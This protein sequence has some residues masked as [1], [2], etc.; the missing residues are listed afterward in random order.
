MNQNDLLSRCKWN[1]LSAIA[2]TPGLLLT[3]QKEA[4]SAKSIPDKLLEQES[5]AVTIPRQKLPSKLLNKPTLTQLPNPIPPRNIEPLEIPK[6]E[7]PPKPQLPI[8]QNPPETPSPPDTL[9]IPQTITVKKFEFAGNTAFSDQELA[10]IVAEITNRP[11]SFAEL[12]QVEEKIRNK[13]TAGC[14]ENGEQPCY[15]NSG[16]FIPANQTFAKDGAIVR[17]QI[18]EGSIEQINITGLKKLNQ[19]YVRSRLQ[20]GISQPLEREQL[21]ETLQILQLDPLIQNFSANLTAGTR[22]EKSILE[23]KLIEADSF[24]VELFTNNGRSPS[25]G[26]WRRGFRVSEDN[27]LGIGDS[28]F[29]EYTNTD[30]S[31]RIDLGYTAPLNASNTTINIIGQIND[32]EVIEEPFDRLDIEGNSFR[33]EL[34]LR[35]PILRTPEQELAVGL[36][37]SRQESITKLL[38]RNFAISSGADDNGS[39]RISALRFYQEYTKRT[40]EDVFAVRSQFSVGLDVFD[41]TVNEDPLPDSL[42]FAWRGQ[43]QYVRRL[44][45]DTLIVLRSDFQLAATNLVPLEQISIGGPE[46]VRGYRQDAILTDNGFFASAE[47]RLPILRA[48]GVQGILQ[49]APFLDFGVGWNAA[50]VEDPEE[51]TFVSLGLG[52]RWQ[53]GDDFSARLEY[54]IPLIDVEDTNETLQENGLYFSINYS[55]F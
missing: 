31:N 25:V 33:I 15:I 46:S 20:R 24:A 9:P 54:G 4:V 6:E 53:M 2:L 42:F 14:N 43:G 19:N 3:S 26:T 5:D 37:G 11:I 21:L 44:A 48:E 27:L 17:V 36:S 7:P 47:V 34:G 49:I 55:P 45:P 39:T 41:A 13:Y 12:L 35:Q 30:G 40:L 52:L 22:P 50:E 10:K 23:I 38:G 1:L 28:I 51:Q 32:T 16:S 18:V 29:G 8:E